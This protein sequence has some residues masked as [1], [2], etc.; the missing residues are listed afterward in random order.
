MEF[1]KPKDPGGSFETKVVDSGQL[2]TEEVEQL[3][4]KVRG[5]V[6][7]EIQEATQAPDSDPAELL[8]SVFR[9]VG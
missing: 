9:Q 4:Q 2:T 6:R 8:S 7:L 5:A 3:T 1:W